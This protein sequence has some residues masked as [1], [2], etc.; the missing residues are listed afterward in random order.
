MNKK[1]LVVIAMFIIVVAFVISWSLDSKSDGL[2][3]LKTNIAADKISIDFDAYGARNDYIVKISDGKLCVYED[4]TRDNHLDITLPN[5]INGQEYILTVEAD[6]GNGKTK[7]YNND[8][9]FVWN[10]PK[11]ALDSVILNDEDYVL[12]I[13]SYINDDHYSITLNNGE[14]ELKKDSI[15]NN[16][17]VISKELFLDQDLIITANLYYDDILLDSVNLYHNIDPLDDITITS[18][19]EGEKLAWDNVLLE[20]S[21]SKNSDEYEIKIYKGKNLI[22]E[23]NTLEQTMLLAKDIFELGK[24]YRIEVKAVCGNYTRTKEVNFSITDKASLPPVYITSDWHLIK[25]G[26]KLALRCDDEKAVIRYTLDGSGPIEKGSEYTEPL[27]IDQD[28]T[29]KTVAISSDKKINNSE[30][31][32]YEVKVGERTELSVFVSPSNQFGNV[33]SENTKFKNEMV[34]MNDIASYLIERLTANGVKVYRNNPGQSI[35][36][37]IQTSKDLNPTLYLSLQSGSSAA[38]DQ[39]GITSWLDMR[40]SEGW[41][42]MK[43]IHQNLLGIYPNKDKKDYDHGINNA[44]GSSKEL[45][46]NKMALMIQVGYHDNDDDANWIMNNKKDIGYNLADSILRYYHVIE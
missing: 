40:E 32:T 18:I 37:Y 14:K 24:N 22:K 26:T 5:L 23:F 8:Y 6:L 34:E 46:S 28:V 43:E 39:Y 31:K 30:V 1:V 10:H 2:R 45:A 16:E 38:H 9:R 20:Y 33:G 13:D 42:L 4:V 7:K 15:S 35:D 41:G 12:Y 29:L 36:E 3:I 27:T 44:N 25:K 11:F 19:K 21:G 17:Y